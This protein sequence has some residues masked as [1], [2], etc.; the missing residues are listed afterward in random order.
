MSP[1][2]NNQ[3]PCKA[4]QTGGALLIIMI[5]MVL[6]VSSIFLAGLDKANGSLAKQKR[7]DQALATAKQALINYA[8]LSDQV[9]GSP[10]VGYLPCPDSDGDGLSDEPCESTGESAEGWL[11]WQ[12]LREKPLKDGHGVCLRYAVSGNYKIDP[13]SALVKMPLTTGHFVIHDQDNTVRV[14]NNAAEYALAVV[15]AA[16]PTVAGQSRGLGGGTATQC[17]STSN[18]SAKNRARNYL[19][20][21]SSVDNARGTYAGAGIPGNT[22]LPASTPSVFIQAEP[23]D[24]FNDRLIWITPADFA[25]VRERMP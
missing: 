19:D 22:S 20:Q 1:R 17:G 18:N 11:P 5:V 4:R 24:G 21:L 3:A 6:F 23:Q 2:F 15:F 9:S 13:A 16:G 25:D 14:G 7:T 8:L 12:T 10:G